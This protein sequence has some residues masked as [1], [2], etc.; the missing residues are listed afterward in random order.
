MRLEYDVVQVAVGGAR[1]V[2]HTTRQF[3]AA[4]GPLRQEIP[5]Q[6]TL[7]AYPGDTVQVSLRSDQLSLLANFS[8]AHELSMFG[9]K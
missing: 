8:K 1:S 6:A 9:L 5:T 7:Y 2:Q 3:T 4:S